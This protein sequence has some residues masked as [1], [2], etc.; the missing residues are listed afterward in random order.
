M[1]SDTDQAIIIPFPDPVL[2]RSI[3]QLEQVAG[4]ELIS[5]VIGADVQPTIDDFWLDELAD[6]LRDRKS[7][8]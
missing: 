4:D 5:T 8:V 1:H 7:V 6:G 2:E 3:D